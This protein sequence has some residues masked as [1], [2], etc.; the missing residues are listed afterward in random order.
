[1]RPIFFKETDSANYTNLI[2]APIF[3]EL[4][5][6]EKRYV[7]ELQLQQMND[8]FCRLLFNISRQVIRC[9]FRSI[10]RMCEVCLE[11]EAKYCDV[12][13][14]NSLVELQGK[15][16]L[17]PVDADV[18]CEES[19]LT[20][21][22]FIGTIIMSVFVPSLVSTLFSFFQPISKKCLFCHHNHRHHHH[23]Q[24]QQHYDHRR[25]RE[26]VEGLGSTT[27]RLFRHRLGRPMHR[28]P[29]GCYWTATSSCQFVPTCFRN[30]L[31]LSLCR[32]TRIHSQ[33]LHDVKGS[34]VVTDKYHKMHSDCDVI[35]FVTVRNSENYFA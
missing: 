12:L 27:Y 29:V 33:T 16:T 9:G 25:R 2:P 34:V 10:L 20:S 15:T 5:D 11:A 3:G 30:K 21:V 1:M 6:E 18:L 19:P 14:C 24:Q 7:N 4:T 23:Q 26:F 28:R 22:A 31:Y 13:L 35:N 8:T 32:G 17:F